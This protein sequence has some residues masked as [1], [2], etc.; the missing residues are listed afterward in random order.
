MI[1]YM[2]KGRDYRGLNLVL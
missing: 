1:K 2:E